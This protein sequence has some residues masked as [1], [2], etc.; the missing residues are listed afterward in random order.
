MNV[1]LFSGPTSEDVQFVASFGRIKPKPKTTMQNVAADRKEITN[2]LSYSQYADDDTNNTA[3]RPTQNSKLMAIQSKFDSLMD[4][5]NAL[6]EG[7]EDAKRKEFALKQALKTEI[8]AKKKQIA[9]K[10]RLRDEIYAMILYSCWHVEGFHIQQQH[11]DQW[12]QIQLLYHQARR[13]FEQEREGIER[14]AAIE[15]ENEQ[16]QMEEDQEGNWN[17]DNQ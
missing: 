3:E 5:V 4:R 11:L 12:P 1:Q 2:I 14:A 10:I 17:G 13:D 8:M 9:S 7:I 15:A 16:K 6:Q